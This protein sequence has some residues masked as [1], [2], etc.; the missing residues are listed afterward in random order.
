MNNNLSITTSLSPKDND[1]NYTA[2]GAVNKTVTS[3]TD[4]EVFYF[5][6]RY[7]AL[8]W[9]HSG[10]EI[11]E[12][13]SLTCYFFVKLDP[14][15]PQGSQR[16]AYQNPRLLFLHPLHVHYSST[17]LEISSSAFTI[18][19]WLLSV[20]FAA[21]S[22]SRD[23]V[24]D[25]RGSARE[26]LDSPLIALLPIL[27]VVEIYLSLGFQFENNLLHN[28]PILCGATIFLTKIILLIVDCLWRKRW[29]VRSF[30]K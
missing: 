15:R 25:P 12:H 23:S 18:Y 11:T 26:I 1:A 29:V 4:K 2:H 13:F 21:T 30:V 7:T 16:E 9:T 22:K 27:N 14:G 10:Q 6:Q 24:A 19:T 20:A 17:R 5:Q 8:S 28:Y 3:W